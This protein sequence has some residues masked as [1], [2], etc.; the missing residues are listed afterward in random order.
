MGGQSC[1]FHVAVWWSWASGGLTSL[2]RG[3]ADGWEE[4]RA[5]VFFFFVVVGR[6]QRL[7][8]GGGH[9]AK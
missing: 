7:R 5:R 9:A 6:R 2:A 1:S 4:V 8:E 3:V